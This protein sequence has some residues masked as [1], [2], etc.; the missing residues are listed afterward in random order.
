MSLKTLNSDCSS[1]NP[2]WFR[3]SPAIFSPKSSGCR[4]LVR[5]LH[6]EIPSAR[7]A[8]QEQ[9]IHLLA[10]QLNNHMQRTLEKKQAALAEQATL[11]NGMS[12]LATLARGYAIARKKNPE[13]GSYRVIDRARDATVGDQLQVLLHEGQLQC[14]VTAR[15]DRAVT[16]TVRAVTSVSRRPAKR[17]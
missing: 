1:A 10:T 7:I 2:I 9:H 6:Q 17:A 4:T 16:G 5:R 15:A 14:L 12:P 13:D 11:L 3:L 8:L